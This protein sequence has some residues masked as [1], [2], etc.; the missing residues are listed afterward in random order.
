MKMNATVKILI[1]EDNDLMREAVA[2][3]LRMERYVIYTA[4]DGPS[5][6]TLARAEQPDLILLD[7]MMPYMPG[8]EVARYLWHDETLCL[9]P[10]I[11]LTAMNKPDLVLDMLAFGNVRDYLLKPVDRA[12]LKH[13]IRAALGESET[14]TSPETKQIHRIDFSS[15][16]KRRNN[17]R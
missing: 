11:I 7:L 15:G 16:G 4:K 1:I 6:I 8:E 12:T 3:M 14:G 9:I 17:G 10:I 13:R 5:G 2:Q